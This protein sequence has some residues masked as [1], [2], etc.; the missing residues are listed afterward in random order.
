MPFKPGHLIA[1]LT[2]AGS[3]AGL[4][5]MMPSALRIKEDYDT[6]KQIEA[7]IKKKIPTAVTAAAAGALAGGAGGYVAGKTHWGTYKMLPEAQG[8]K[9]KLK[10][11]GS[12]MFGRTGLEYDPSYSQIANANSRS[13]Q[14]MQSARRELPPALVNDMPDYLRDSDAYGNLSQRF[15]EKHSSVLRLGMLDKLGLGW[16]AATAIGGALAAGTAA[17]GFLV[18]KNVLDPLHKKNQQ[19]IKRWQAVDK[20]LVPG[21]AAAGTLV[22][23]ITGGAAGKVSGKHQVD[24]YHSDLYNAGVNDYYTNELNNRINSY[25]RAK[26]DLARQ[27]MNE[28]RG[29]NGWSQNH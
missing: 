9:A 10:K 29:N 20:Y 21:A 19:K 3:L 7:S 11:F 1:G 6:S 12:A 28:G 14:A 16:G 18:K 24:N 27:Y 25:E 17:G 26:I 13:F 5:A 15:Y 22:G 4:A 23:G 8:R 2:A